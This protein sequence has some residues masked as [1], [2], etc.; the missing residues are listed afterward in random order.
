MAVGGGQGRSQHGGPG[1]HSFVDCRVQV[2]DRE[3]RRDPCDLLHRL[4]GPAEQQEGAD[5]GQN[6]P[7]KA[8]RV[9]V[10]PVNFS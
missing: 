10:I 7:A 4:V 1:R 9:A 6:Y 5:A 8:N 2:D 3:S